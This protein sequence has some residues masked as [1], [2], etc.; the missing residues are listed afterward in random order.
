VLALAQPPT[1]SG[2]AHKWE[3]MASQLDGA[4]PSDAHS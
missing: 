1:Q 3:G 4:K 2:G